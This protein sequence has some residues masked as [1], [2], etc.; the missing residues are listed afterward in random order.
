MVFTM[1][2]VQILIFWVVTPCSDVVGYQ[3]LGGPWWKMD[4]AILPY[5]YTVSQH[6]RPRHETM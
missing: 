3:R 6:R 4:V 2:N 1:M 5:H